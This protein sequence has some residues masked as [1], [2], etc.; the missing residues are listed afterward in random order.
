LPGSND[1][2]I[3][4]LLAL[5]T[6]RRFEEVTLPAVAERAGITLAELRKSYD[7]RL[8]VFAD[9]VRQVD[10]RVLAGI[11][12]ALAGEP[13]RERLFD[14]LF[15]RFEAHAPNREALRGIAAAACRDPLLALELNR[16][17]TMSMG[18]MLSAAGIASTGSRGL[19][20][21]QGLAMVWARVFRV[22][23]KDEEAGLPRTMA[24]LDKALRDAERVVI[25]IDRVEKI[26]CRFRRSRRPAQET[27]AAGD[28]PEAH[29][30]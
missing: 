15:A 11:D 22:W 1:K 3:E 29:P 17:V 25:C 19:V 10:E 13:P 20:R 9:Y 26:F 27:A 5:A 7:S 24:A 6:E 14:V 2:I 21:A 8:S 28:L 16:L 4:A 30:T 23:L 12:P 18:W